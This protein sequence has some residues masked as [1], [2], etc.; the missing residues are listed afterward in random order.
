MKLQKDAD[1]FPTSAMLD[2]EMLVII[3]QKKAELDTISVQFCDRISSNASWPPVV[4]TTSDIHTY[5]VSQDKTKHTVLY[6]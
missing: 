1:V 6:L 5:L 2:N 4:M 3:M